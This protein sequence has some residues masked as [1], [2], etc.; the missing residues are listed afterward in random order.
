MGR[1]ARGALSD[2]ARIQ[3]AGLVELLPRLGP[4]WMEYRRV[5]KR[6]CA[7]PPDLAVFIDLPDIHLRLAKEAKT[8]GIPVYYI[9]APQ[10]WAWR[11]NR[12][13]SL[14]ESLDR[15][16]ALF[17][18][19]AQWFAARGVP[20]DYIGHPLLDRAP[21]FAFSDPRDGPVR[22]GLF[23]GSRS[24]EV[25]AVLPVQLRAARRLAKRLDI[26]CEF[27]VFPAPGRE[28]RIRTLCRRENLS[29]VFGETGEALSLAW[30]AAGTVTTELAL[31]GIPLLVTHRV[32]PLSYWIA[33]RL[34]RSP[35]IGMPN[36]LLNRSAAPEL[37]QKACTAA[38][39]EKESVRLLTEGQ[40]LDA[41][42]ADW[43]S[44]R[45]DWLRVARAC[46]AEA[47]WRLL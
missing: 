32:R 9:A 11:G 28:E 43:R 30:C 33:K 27:R 24:H 6:L 44:L 36:I 39:I 2:M 1:V 31:A 46:P 29:P 17:P 42:R 14:S 4:L 41:M 19:E 25:A 15:L 38:N 20:T 47:A 45:A 12:L 3:A 21:R 37:I 16:G 23:P 18:F 8:S 35:W 40:N 26:P 5:L 7:D 34:V 22:L 13:R 10:L